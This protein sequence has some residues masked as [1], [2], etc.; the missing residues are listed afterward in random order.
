MDLLWVAGLSAFV[1]LEKITPA[2]REPIGSAALAVSCSS[3]GGMDRFLA[4]GS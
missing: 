1:L 3:A 2:D 4:L